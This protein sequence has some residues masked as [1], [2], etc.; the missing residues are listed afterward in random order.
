MHFA[1]G[2]SIVRSIPSNIHPRISFLVAHVPSAMSFFSET[3]GPILL[4]VM[5]GGGNTLL[6]PSNIR[7]EHCRSSC[8]LVV[9]ST[10]IKSSMYTSSNEMN[11]LFVSSEFVGCGSVGTEGQSMSIMMFSIGCSGTCSLEFV[12]S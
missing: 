2:S 12:F 8:S 6:I 9:C 7:R 4:P 10:P 5:F 11:L 3:G 1:S